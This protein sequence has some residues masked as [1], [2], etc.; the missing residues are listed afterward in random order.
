MTDFQSDS[1]LERS[2]DVDIEHVLD[3][4]A[5][6]EDIVSDDHERDEVQQVRSLLEHVPGTSTIHKY[7]SRDMGESFIGGLVFSLPLLV[8][9]GVF[10]I[11][12]WFTEHTLGPVPIFL[13]A[14]I[15]FVFILA[16]GLLYAVDIRE[17][18]VTKPLLGFIPRR[19][20][21]VLVISFVCAAGMMFM[22]GRLHEGDPSTTESF[23]RATVIWAS[24]ALG[25]VL[26]DIL[27]GESKGEDVSYLLQRQD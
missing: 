21:G 22:W 17:V 11:A 3:R 2:K 25:A 8:E 15:A 20:I 13:A 26:G 12:S 7:T 6:L 24:A 9:D 18:R 14:N 10:D 19:L 4:L 5:E 23:A 27:P 16:A 1:H